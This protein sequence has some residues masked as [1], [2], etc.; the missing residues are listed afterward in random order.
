M[1]RSLFYFIV[2]YLASP[3]LSYSQDV[4]FTKEIKYIDPVDYVDDLFDISK[5]FDE[6]KI[7]AVGEATHG[8]SEFYRF[9]HRLFEF[10][11]KNHGFRLFG[12]EAG[13]G[14]V[15][16]INEYLST[17]V[18]NPKELVSDIGFWTYSTEEVLDLVNWMRS[19]NEENPSDQ[20]NIYGFDF[21]PLEILK[22]VL[23]LLEDY[24]FEGAKYHKDLPD[25]FK[26]YYVVSKK[27]KK[28]LRKTIANIGSEYRRFSRRNT[29]DSKDHYLILHHFNMLDQ[30]FSM[31]NKKLSR[32][33]YRDKKMAEN[34]E[35]VMNHEDQ[36]KMFIWAHNNHIHK[37]TYFLNYKSM[38]QH[39]KKNHGQ[40]YYALGLTFNQGYFNAIDYETRKLKEFYIRDT[41]SSSLGSKLE[42]FPYN[43][44][45][46]DL[47]R[48]EQKEKKNNYFDKKATTIS[49][50]ALYNPRY[51][52]NKSEGLSKRFDGVVHMKNTTSAVQIDERN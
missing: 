24:E 26:K 36:N 18:G 41:L 14:E 22:N 40:G 19:H 47:N 45:F 3:F 31:S 35:W 42:V 33:Y 38:G 52:F 13:F 11:V 4:S 25:N 46:I 50:G 5:H 43:N 17:G 23:T 28:A 15:Y 51:N 16:R 9:K 48:L 7:I 29:I 12:I 30:F 49:I 10:L 39:L 44:V 2:I 27:E 8:T 37:K 6:K 21:L 34:I 20:I 32:G 1:K